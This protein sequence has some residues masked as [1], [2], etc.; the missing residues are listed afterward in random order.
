MLGSDFTQSCD[1]LDNFTSSYN[2]NDVGDQTTSSG[3]IFTFDDI[4]VKDDKSDFKSYFHLQ[5]SSTKVKNG[6]INDTVSNWNHTINRSSVGEESLDI[7][8]TLS[9]DGSPDSVEDQLAAISKTITFSDVDLNRYVSDLLESTPVTNVELVVTPAGVLNSTG[10]RRM[11]K[12]IYQT[13]ILTQEFAKN[14]CW[15]REDMLAI[16]KMTGLT[17]NQIYKWYWEQKQTSKAGAK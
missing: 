12:S 17:Q 5:N 13:K 3:F 4:A 10:K 11:R 9:S 7:A 2:F 16:S 6:E 15:S 14:S 8:F 1:D